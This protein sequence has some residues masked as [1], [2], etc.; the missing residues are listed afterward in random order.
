MIELFIFVLSTGYLILS[1]VFVNNIKT[2]EIY[3]DLC[4][5]SGTLCI[6][7][8]LYLYYKIIKI[9]KNVI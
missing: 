9:N 1:D 4:K 3:N 5:L 6:T 7:V 2:E 8:L